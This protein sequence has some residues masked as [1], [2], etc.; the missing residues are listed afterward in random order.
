MSSSFK[1]G[2]SPQCYDLDLSYFYAPS[3]NPS[4]FLPSLPTLYPTCLTPCSLSSQFCLAPQ[5]YQEDTWCHM[6]TRA[7]QL[8]DGAGWTGQQGPS[9]GR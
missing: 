3:Q 1:P 7:C 6:V 5:L 2:P 9:V 4:P 8:M